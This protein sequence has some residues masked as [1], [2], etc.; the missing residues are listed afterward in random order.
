[1]TH[2]PLVQVSADELPPL[3]EAMRDIQTAVAAYHAETARGGDLGARVRAFLVN[4]QT[5]ND[6]FSN[7]IVDSASYKALYDPP[8]HVNADLINGVK[9]ARNVTQHVLHIVRP[10]EDTLVG[11]ALGMRIYAYWDDIPSHA[12]AKLRT[13]TQKLKPAYDATLLGQ[14]VTGTMFA[15]LRFYAE[16]EPTIV[17]RDQQGEWTG[18]PLMNQPG[19]STPLH[20]DEPIDLAPARAWL[21]GRLPNGDLRV[22]CGQLTVDSTHYVFGHTFVG[23]YSFAPFVETIEQANRDIDSGFT[24]LIGDLSKNVEDSSEQ[25]SLALQGAVLR[26]RGDVTSWASPIKRVVGQDED[27]C[28]NCDADVWRH[29]ISLERESTV[30]EMVAY[31]IRRARRLN[32]FVP[33][34][35]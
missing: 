33:P 28:E 26:S 31:E 11:G 7:A 19:M 34:S 23:P 24:Y 16:I 22:V 27:W 13:N 30:P 3:R 25:F 18:F 5:L 8:A 9:Y 35:I 17:H 12:H 1:M 21:D 29:V 2:K 32:A 14:E 20:P 15:V 4:A 10:S 6:L